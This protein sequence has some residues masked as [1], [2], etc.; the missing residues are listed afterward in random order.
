MNKVVLRCEG[1][2]KSFRDGALQ[3]DVLKSVD[4]TLHAGESVAIVGASGE[5]KSTLLHLLGGLDQPSSGEVFVDQQP[6]HA[7]NEK[8]RCWVRNHRLGFVYQFHHLLPEFTLLENV[9]MPLLVRGSTPKL[10]QQ[11][12]KH[13]ID[14]VG[15]S[16][17]LAHK[18]AELSGGERQRTAIARALVTTPA[19]LLA[20][21]PTGN[22]DHQTAQQVFQT[23]LDLKRDLNTSL[24]I[25]THD[26]QLARRMD[27]MLKLESGE[28][29]SLKV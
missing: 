24:L 4:F 10:A 9:C 26:L 21:E 12:A 15:L 27:R 20:D 8:K 17:R 19:C 25:V 1:L 6:L 22:L 5:G 16:H 29:H 7:L 13:I 2:R 11:K 23:M 18:P 28:L 3:V 14:S